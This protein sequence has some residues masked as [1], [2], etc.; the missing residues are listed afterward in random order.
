MVESEKKKFT[1]AVVGL[2]CFYG[3]ELNTMS[4]AIYWDTLREHELET[5][6]DAMRC[7]VKDPEHGRFMPKP[8]DIVRHLPADRIMGADAA[9]EVAMIS[10]LWD[11]DATIVVSTAMFRSFPFAIWDMGDKVGARTAFKDAYPA[12]LAKYGDQ[13]V[14][15]LGHHEGSR[16][17]AV[18]DAVR[19][20]MIEQRTARLLL[21]HLTDAEFASGAGPD[22]PKNLGAP[23]G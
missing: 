21:P 13:V 22:E 10:R 4:L 16:A 1:A 3:V 9:W 5:V 18:L 2:A 20:G 14:V 19:T 15:S 6:R 7:H 8:A 17:P 12:A 23:H 11:E